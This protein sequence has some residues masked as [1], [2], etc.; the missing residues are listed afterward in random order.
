MV[1]IERCYQ[2]NKTTKSKLYLPTTI[3]P[4]S[5]YHIYEIASLQR[6]NSYTGSSI[7][8]INYYYDKLIRLTFFPIQNEYFDK[9]CKIKRKPLIYFLLYF[10]DCIQNNKVFTYEDISHLLRFKIIIY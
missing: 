8:M 9:K 2:Y 3:I 6:Y 5:E 4:L 10:R 1:G 7:S